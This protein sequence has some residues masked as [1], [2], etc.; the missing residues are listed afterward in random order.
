MDLRRSA[1]YLSR[2][3]W[4]LIAT[5]VVLV[6]LYVSLG[7]F[8]LP[9]IGQHREWLLHEITTRTGLDIRSDSLA[10]RWQG[11]SPTVVV[12]GLAVGDS[13]VGPGIVATR[14]SVDF[15]VPGSIAAGSPLV[16]SVAVDGLQVSLTQAADGRWH[17]SGLQPGGGNPAWVL[18]LLQSARGIDLTRARL[19]L[20]TASGRTVALGP[21]TIHYH[22]NTVSGGGSLSL[23]G[24]AK[25]PPVRIV[26]D[27]AGDWSDGN[28]EIRLALHVADFDTE[29]IGAA[30]GN[31]VIRRVTGL[32][33]DLFANYRQGAGIDVQGKLRAERLVGAGKSGEPKLENLQTSLRVAWSTQQTRAWLKGTSFR[34]DGTD[35]HID[36]ITASYRP[37]GA[38]PLHVAVGQ[39]DV[40]KLAREALLWLPKGRLADTFATLDP[41]G[42]VRNLHVDIPLA[43]DK[44]SALK[45]QATLAGVSLQSWKGAPGAGGVSG[46]FTGGVDYGS[47]DLDD[48]S[49][50][51]E[52][53]AV[54]G[55]V[56]TFD[57]ASGQV[58]WRIGS[59]VVRVNSGLISVAG[60]F[61][62]AVAQIDLDIPLHHKPGQHAQMSLLVGLQNSDAKYRNR[63]IP[64]LVSA[65][66]RKWLDDSIRSGHIP[67]AGFIY[68]GSLGG[69]DHRTR[70]I[71]LYLDVTGGELAYHPEWPA[72]S[73]VNARVLMDNGV[74]KA[75]AD[76]AKVY[77]SRVVNANVLIEPQKN[78]LRLAVTGE[79]DGP[80][81]D[82]V[83]LLRETPLN[84]ISPGVFS[85]WNLTG[86]YR[87]SVR[88]VTRLGSGRDATPEVSAKVALDNTSVTYQ[89]LN[90]KLEGLTGPVRFD[91][92]DGF[93]A[94]NIKG[95]F[96]GR[97]LTLSA[98]SQWSTTGDRVTDVTATA[99]LTGAGLKRW[100]SLPEMQ[101]LKGAAPLSAS[102]RIAT[103]PAAPVEARIDLNSTLSGLAVELPPPFGKTADSATA[104]DVSIPLPSSSKQPATVRIGDVGAGYFWLTSGAGID[105]RFVL[106]SQSPKRQPLAHS[107]VEVTGSVAQ[108]DVQQWQPVVK[109]VTTQSSAGAMH[110]IWIHQLRIGSLTA[111]GQR[112]S[113]P[114]VGMDTVDGR[115]TLSIV[116]PRISGTVA[117]PV[118]NGALVVRLDRLE[119]PLAADGNG[120]KKLFEGGGDP[121]AS[122]TPDSL[123]PMDVVVKQFAVNGGEW[124][125]WQFHV[126]P[127]P[128]AVLI[129]GL[130]ADVRGITV[131]GYDADEG[132]TV[133]WQWGADGNQST[134]FDGMLLTG[135]VGDVLQAFGHEASVRSEKARFLTG[136]RW[137]GS[138]AAISFRNLSG[139]I[140]VDMKD[141][142][143][144]ET[145]SAATGALKVLGVLN[146]NNL[147]R[148]LRLDFSDLYKKGL[149]YDSVRGILLFTPGELT[150]REPLVVKGPS[151]DFQLTG[152]LD[153]D[154]E[155]MD[156][157]L[158]VTLP[159][160]HNLPWV[161]ALAGG[162]AV[163]AGVYVA[164]KVFEKQLDKL[165][166][167]VYEVK[168]P[169]S[170]PEIEFKRLFDVKG[171]S[172]QDSD[173]NQDKN[174][175]KSD[176]GRGDPAKQ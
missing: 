150:V 153:L 133:R 89:P 78:H 131:T 54:Y 96:L 105:G 79:V 12:G 4:G 37:G 66:L 61:G 74:V 67:Q 38:A 156:V 49:L 87:G 40:G 42:T 144:L 71:E 55:D 47:V 50:T 126:R 59:D 18:R 108:L 56:L 138:P 160:T 39:L 62:A 24:G 5:A 21:L 7:R 11:F 3:L 173:K 170:D 163:A 139:D 29:N 13:K 159:I 99:E 103:H 115:T 95:R 136:L 158:V 22:R 30:L 171:S 80:S 175:D 112:L 123:I 141:G 165:T 28:F 124:G 114:V 168:G 111:W 120:D 167:A 25:T 86:K 10:G 51:L 57:H 106:G 1:G 166:S 6:A 46:V 134:A 148:R 2:V 101:F 90:L 174:R 72:L 104:L 113:N 162:P 154:R 34:L 82:I 77:N 33:V 65:D 58:R 118:G 41:K 23:G 16:H 176:A 9:L 125:G 26:T 69:N 17:L 152:D 161:A 117:L 116:H 45:V 149:S 146:F 91:T 63:F 92:V 137:P 70:S 76:N 15:N 32:G 151:S 132:A 64:D 109:A 68:Y 121:L 44:L 19:T 14:I 93:S 145:T 102:V 84:R 107:G 157:Q 147:A 35:W 36:R 143:F 135:D 164:G 75:H 73:N 81:R 142:R 169:W 140:E 97:P 130:K 122:V 94:R 83:S 110:G 155:L 98:R 53:P 85:E 128:H 48:K 43:R 172:K 119:L 60:D 20:H 100:S 8:Y 88:L 27:T 52:F 129:D 127:Q 31:P